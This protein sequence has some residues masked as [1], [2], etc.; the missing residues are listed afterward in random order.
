MLFRSYAYLTVRIAGPDVSTS[1]EGNIYINSSHPEAISEIIAT[2]EDN[3]NEFINKLD[4]TNLGLDL[5]IFYTANGNDII[6]TVRQN[7]IDEAFSQL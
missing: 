1:S 6:E 7:A 4:S 3:F 5:A 2:A